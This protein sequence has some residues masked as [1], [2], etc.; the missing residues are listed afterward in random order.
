MTADLDFTTPNLDQLIR[1]GEEPIRSVIAVHPFHN[2]HVSDAIT[3]LRAALLLHMPESSITF[4]EEEM[5]QMVNSGSVLE[6]GPNTLYF[7]LSYPTAPGRTF[8]MQFGAPPG[9]SLH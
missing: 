3:Q 7:S 4:L 1:N 8:E 6:L 9:V 5:I 2:E